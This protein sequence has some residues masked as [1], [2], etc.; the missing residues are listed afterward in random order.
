QAD[1]TLPNDWQNNSQIT[2]T[3]D[4]S[5]GDFASNIA[6]TAAKAAKANPRQLAEKI[7]NA[8]PD[9]QNIRQVEIAGPGFINV[10]LNAEAKFAVLDDIFKRQERFGLSDQ[11]EG[12]KVQVEFVSANPTSSLHV[13][14]GR[15]AAFGMSVANLLEAVGYDVTREYYVNDA[16]RQMDILATSTYLRYLEV[17]GEQITFPVNGYQ[18]EYVRD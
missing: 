5:H 10:F 6:L 14:H 2:R 13:G 8:L 7:V 16:G 4:L 17:N 15:G 3:K 11:F 12:Q 9:N 18:G 1:G